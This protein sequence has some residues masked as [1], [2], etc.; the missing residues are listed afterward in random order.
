M[1]SNSAAVLLR[2]AILVLVGSGLLVGCG[3]SSGNN[4]RESRG[5]I[6]P[7]GAKTTGLPMGFPDTPEQRLG[8]DL[9]PTPYTAAEIREECPA[10][11]K[12]TFAMVTQKGRFVSVQ[13]FV[14]VSEEGA[15]IK[16]ILAEVFDDPKRRPPPQTEE[17]LVTWRDLQSHASYPAKDTT[18][19]RERI[20]VRAGWYDCWLYEV[21]EGLTLTKYWF[22]S[23]L[24]GPPV[25]SE[26]YRGNE[27]ILSLE[28]T[29][30]VM[31]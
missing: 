30:L 28:L 26:V 6:Q 3:T 17:Q 10:G 12:N 9:A 31:P 16:Q 7:A 24:A 22:P 2:T 15:K 23:E 5:S 27:L 19:R 13:H 21:R 29:E 4:S 8:P 18:I 20:E 14:E 11:R 1:R 25:K